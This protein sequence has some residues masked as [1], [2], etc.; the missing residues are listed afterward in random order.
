MEILGI[1]KA[2]EDS[3]TTGRR[4]P[5][6]VCKSVFIP[7]T[8]SAV[9]ITS[10]FSTYELAYKKKNWVRNKSHREKSQMGN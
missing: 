8:K 5:N 7:E 10:A 6:Q 4:V 3:I 1:M 2:Y 9:S